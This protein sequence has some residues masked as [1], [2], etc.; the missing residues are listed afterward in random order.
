MHGIDHGDDIFD[1]RPRLDVM[2]RVKNEP[3][4]RREDLAPAQNLFADFSRR[5]EG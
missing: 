2:N 1:R 5:S 3:P 4:A